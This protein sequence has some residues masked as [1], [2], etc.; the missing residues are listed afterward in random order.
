MNVWAETKFNFAFFDQV[1]ELDWDKKVQE[2]IPKVTEENNIEDYY[3]LLK[4]MVVCLKDGHTD[5]S[6]PKNKKQGKQYDS[7]PIEIQ[8][9]EDKFIITRC[10][11]TKEIENQN[12]YPGLEII[13][14]DS[15]PTH[16]YFNEH[17]LRYNSYSTKQSDEAFGVRK[18]LRGLKDSKVTLEIAN[19]QGN[20]RAV[21]L[22][23]N[24]NIN[25]K[26]RFEWR[27]WMEEPLVEMKKLK[28]NI[29]YFKL[30][31][32]SYSKIKDEFDEKFNSL[33]LNKIKGIILD[34]RYNTGGSTNNGY[35]II[36]NFIDTPLKSSNWKTRKYLPSYRAWGREEE[37]Y[38]CGSHGDIEPSE[39][40]RYLG[41]LVVLIGPNTFS[42]AEDFVVPFDFADRAILVG[43]KTGGSTGQP[44]YI[45]LP[46]GG[47]FQVCTKRD[48]YPDGKEFVGYGIEPDI[49]VHQSQKDIY[50]GFDR[51]LDKGI[52]VIKN[53]AKYQNP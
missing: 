34:V 53:W 13:S 4:E 48:T 49:E 14:I 31:S 35:A 12:I 37:W 11:N 22:T 2:Y 6:F 50:D 19:L 27:T 40:N 10:G 51:V 43:Q 36:S 52:E 42:A 24:L 15:I 3:K 8:V 32:F 39:G 30:A 20:I 23:R 47:S 46:G 7:P 9:V 1:P 25:D 28:G 41:P 5:I 38:E 29:I 33:N 16:Q 45:F 26:V 21:K 44:L 18:L 17:I